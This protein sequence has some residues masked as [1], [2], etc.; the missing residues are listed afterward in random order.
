MKKVIA[1]ALQLDTLIGETRTNLENCKRLALT[2][3]EKGASW[4]ALP[5]FFNTGIIFDPKLKD[6]IEVESGVSAQ[7]M[8]NFSKEHSIV[9]GGSFLCWVPEGGVRNR[10]LCFSNGELIGKHD[11][12]YPTMYEN[13]FYEGGEKSDIGLL[14]ETENTRVGTAVCWEFM[15]TG[16]SKRLRNKVDVIIGGSHWWSIPSD[17]SS[18]HFRRLEENNEKTS[19]LCIQETARLIGAPVIHAA[20]CNKV[21]YKALGAPLIYRGQME[22]NAAIIDAR[23][24]I[25]ARRSKEEGEGIVLA[26]VE[27]KAVETNEVIPKRF[28]LL[29]PNWVSLCAWYYERFQGKRWYK[30]NIRPIEYSSIVNRNSLKNTNFRQRK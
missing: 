18:P 23:G 6:A 17:W 26:E 11:K 4:I 19:L 8:R 7:F 24:K 28:W 9:I 27:L 10:Y 3:I 29:R 12:D 15:R 30:K 2:A 22:G 20:H 5:E 25:L 13:A 16:T 21:K 14:G 1:A